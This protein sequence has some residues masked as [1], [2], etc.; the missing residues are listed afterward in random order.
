MNKLGHIQADNAENPESVES[1]SEWEI[2]GEGLLFEVVLAAWTLEN[3]SRCHEAGGGYDMH[4]A[5]KIA[6]LNLYR[7]LKAIEE[8]TCGNQ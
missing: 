8:H 2:T 3:A 5:I 1:I 7:K 6:R 4:M